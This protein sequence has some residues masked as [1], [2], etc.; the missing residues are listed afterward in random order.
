MS[1]I[2]N[3]ITDAE[4]P[5]CGGTLRPIDGKGN[6]ECDGCPWIFHLHD[7]MYSPI[8]PPTDFEM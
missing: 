1:A 3:I 2:K 4:C 6:W 7:G 5:H 8:D